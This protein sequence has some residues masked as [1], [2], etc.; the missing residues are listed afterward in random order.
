[1]L[2]ANSVRVAVRYR[3]RPD[4]ARAVCQSILDQGQVTK[5]V[6][7]DHWDHGSISECINGA[8]GSLDILF[9]NA[10][11]ASVGHKLPNGDLEALTPEIWTEMLNVNL[12]EP[13]YLTRAAA[14]HLLTSKW[15][16]VINLSSIIGPGVWGAA[17]A[18]T[19]SKAAVV[20]LTRFFVSDISSESHSKLHFPGAHAGHTKCPGALRMNSFHVAGKV[21][22]G[23]NDTHRQGCPT[24]FGFL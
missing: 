19:S 3:F 12:S 6:R 18:F 22:F 16:R 23:R 4:R 1:M 17:V 9:N 21:D 14:R 2:A 8:F 10:G 13:Y 5:E 24:G 20:P 11:M 7:I 15:G